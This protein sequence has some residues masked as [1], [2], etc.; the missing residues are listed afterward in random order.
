MRLCVSLKFG[1]HGNRYIVLSME[2]I[3]GSYDDRLSSSTVTITVN[4]WGSKKEEGKTFEFDAELYPTWSTPKKCGIPQNC[5]LNKFL[6]PYENEDFH[7][8]IQLCVPKLSM[9]LFM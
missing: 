6:R 3:S 8:D 7:I 5:D 4:V 1:A 9:R 2:S